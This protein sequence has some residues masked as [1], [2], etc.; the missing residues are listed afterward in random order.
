MN[1]KSKKT[2]IRHQVL[3]NGILVLAVVITM[4][5]GSYA[6]FN[7]Q[8]MNDEYNAF[9]E[10]DFEISYVA[11][12]DGYGD[13]LSLVGETSIP[14]SEGIKLKPYRFSVMNLGN[15]EKNFKLKIN[16]DQSII[17]EDGCINKLLSTSYIKYKIDNQPPKILKVTESKDYEIYT[18]SETIMPGSSEI[19]ELRIWI[20]ENSP[21]V[22]KNKHFHATVNV[23]SY[24]KS[25]AYD[26]YTF[27]QE[28]TLLDG[29]KYH[30]LEDS[31]SD[32]SK[33]KLISDYN[34]NSDG[35]QD[36]KCIISDFIKQKIKQEEQYLYCSTVTLDDANTLLYGKFLHNLQNNL[37]DYETRIDNIEVR[38]PE[39][40]ELQK[41]LSIDENMVIDKTNVLNI[42]WL[43][44]LNFWTMTNNDK[45]INYNY[46]LSSDSTTLSLKQYPKESKYFGLRP[47]IIIEKDNIKK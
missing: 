38:L 5:G 14:D 46:T 33:V 17:E 12:E 31:S 19:H 36:T 27:G 29:S 35:N 22:V 42:S 39:K 11:E 40:E 8:A 34:I 3:I 23:E 43:V 47:V 13:I 16:L 45:D 44:N 30:V 6:W 7:S 37:K 18:S 21:E 25:N 1:N 9:K 28:V 15:K 4:V 26:S 32:S 2:V 41:A 20:D 24:D 10:D